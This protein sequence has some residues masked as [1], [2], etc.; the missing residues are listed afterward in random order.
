MLSTLSGFPAVLQGARSIFSKP[1]PPKE[2]GLTPMRSHQLSLGPQVGVGLET[3]SHSTLECGLAWPCPGVTQAATVAVSSQWRDP[4]SS[5]NSFHPVPF[6]PASGALTGSASPLT[7]SPGFGKG[8][9]IDAGLVTH[10]CTDALTGCEFLHSIFF[11]E[12]Y[13]LGFT[14]PSK[15]ARKPVPLNLSMPVSL[16]NEHVTARLL[17]VFLIFVINNLGFFFF[18]FLKK[19]FIYFFKNSNC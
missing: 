5:R 13:L 17:R 14:P 1:H 19:V 11:T 6:F 9:D 2:N 3:P 7:R 8:C 16:R 15:C 12:W 4:A 10:H 18:F